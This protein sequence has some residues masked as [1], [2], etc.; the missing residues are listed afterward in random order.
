LQL[1]QNW[2]F[3]PQSWRERDI[4]DLDYLGSIRMD[5]LAHEGLKE[6]VKQFIRRYFAFPGLVRGSVAH[7]IITKALGG[8]AM[9]SQALCITVRQELRA[10]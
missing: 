9:L 7:C 1:K 5:E 2:S 6:C 10:D 4:S 3:A 8:I